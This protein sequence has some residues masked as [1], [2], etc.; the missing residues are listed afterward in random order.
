[1]DS[2]SSSSFRFFPVAAD[3]EYEPPFPLHTRRQEEVS[4]FQHHWTIKYNL[5]S[6]T[7]Q[8]DRR[9]TVVSKGEKK[10]K[11]KKQKL[12]G[13]DAYRLVL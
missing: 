10:K 13:G 1:L 2:Y 12:I 9:E 8:P 7:P 6:V 5:E 4:E 3:V 11:K